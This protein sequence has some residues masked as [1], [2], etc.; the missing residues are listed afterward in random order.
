[1]KP[2]LR[3]PAV[4]FAAFAASFLLYLFGLVLPYSL[5]AHVARTPISF[6]EIA[7]R[8]PL[9]ALAFLVTFLLLF[10]LYALVYRTCRRHPRQ[11]SPA[12]ILLCGLTLALL[13]S[14]TCPVGAGD[15]VDYVT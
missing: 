15:V 7:R 10:G 12:L 14:F 9:P 13:V 4:I 1:M 8:E 5:F 2:G 11:V 3:P 6:P